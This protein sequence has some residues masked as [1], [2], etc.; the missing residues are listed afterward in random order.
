MA[1]YKKLIILIIVLLLVPF[2]VLLHGCRKDDKESKSD[3]VS[4]SKNNPVVTLEIENKGNIKIELYPDV[5]P[6]TVNNFISLVK[7]G[8]YDGLIFHR[9]IS[10]FIIQGGCPEGTGYG[11]PG[12]SIRGEFDLNNHE[13]PL[14]HKRG[15]ISMARSSMSYDSAGSQFFI[16][17][18]DSPHLDGG[19][20]SFGRVI[21]GMDVVDAIAAADTDENDR[22][23]E[24]QV[25]KRVTVETFGIEYN[26]PVI[27]E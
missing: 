17:V 25:I 19:Y 12:Y 27:I 13:N 15:V 1:F 10:D 21:E 20:A 11:G 22:P 26:D 3:Y 9:V 4:K 8:F 5:A 18:K 14:L 24:D 16:V 23:Y 6:N 2:T 7:K